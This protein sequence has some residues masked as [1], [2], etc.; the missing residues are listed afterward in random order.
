M[1]ASMKKNGSDPDQRT[2]RYRKMSFGA[3]DPE[4][5]V[6]S[7]AASSCSGSGE[8]NSN[9]SEASC[10]QSD[11]SLCDDGGSE[12]EGEGD[13]ILHHFDGAVASEDSHDAKEDGEDSH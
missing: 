2:Q 5:E 10:S 11:I 1:L 7:I 8:L 6:R 4:D 12:E 3:P 13:G 9:I